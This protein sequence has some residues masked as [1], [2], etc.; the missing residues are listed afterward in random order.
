MLSFRQVVS[1]GAAQIANFRAY[2]D[3]SSLSPAPLRPGMRVIEI[4]GDATNITNVENENMP[5]KFMENG[6]LYIRH[7]GV[8]YDMTG[9]IVK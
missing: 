4:E 1:G 9:R 3:L 6:Q 8:V 2:F 7:E 5:V